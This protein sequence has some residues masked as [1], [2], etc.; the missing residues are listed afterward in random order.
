MQLFNRAL[1]TLLDLFELFFHLKLLEMI[2]EETNCFDR[3]SARIAQNDTI[4]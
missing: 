4:P 3:N 2:V 1:A